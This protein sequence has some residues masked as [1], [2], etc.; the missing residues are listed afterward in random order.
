MNSRKID[1]LE[2]LDRKDAV[3]FQKERDEA[4]RALLVQAKIIM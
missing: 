3:N 4:I 1:I 2:M